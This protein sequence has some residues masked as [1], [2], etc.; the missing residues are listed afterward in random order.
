MACTEK[1][2]TLSV[3]FLVVSIVIFGSFFRGMVSCE[4]LNF[5]FFLHQILIQTL[6]SPFLSHSVSIEKLLKDFK[7][8][9]NLQK[10]YE[11]IKEENQFLN[12]EI[13]LAEEQIRELEKVLQMVSRKTDIQHTHIHRHNT[14]G[15]Q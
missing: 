1:L 5:R 15:A 9:E 3:F 12:C 10:E 11:L 8:H 4:E 7:E 13:S 14:D 6:F 2:V